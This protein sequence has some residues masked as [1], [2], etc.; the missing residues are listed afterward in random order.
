M[1]PP[2]S[3]VIDAVRVASELR[4]TVGEQ[5]RPSGLDAP[6]SYP[7]PSAVGTSASGPVSRQIR[8]DDPLHVAFNSHS[9]DIPRF[10]DEEGDGRLGLSRSDEDMVSDES[11]SGDDGRF[12]TDTEEVHTPVALDAVIDSFDSERVATS[13][14]DFSFVTGRKYRKTRRRMRS[15]PSTPHD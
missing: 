10:D 9:T 4:V 3:T 12:L 5:T 1:V 7:L 14:Q 13:S 2:V 15:R 6:V 11:G 8:M